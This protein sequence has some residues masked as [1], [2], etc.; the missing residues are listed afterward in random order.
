VP[1]K[2]PLQFHAALGDTITFATT[3]QSLEHRAS[4]VCD[5]GEW[6]YYKKLKTKEK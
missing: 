4:V 5:T 1:I 6:Q 2:S 3:L